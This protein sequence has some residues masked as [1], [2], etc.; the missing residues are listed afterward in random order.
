MSTPA[1]RMPWITTARRASDTKEPG[2]TT[3]LDWIRLGLRDFG[4]A[5]GLSLLYG[6]L[7]SGMCACVFALILVFPWFT[8][9]FLTAL[10][11]VAPFF[12][13]ILYATS[14]DIERDTV[15]SLSANLRLVFRRRTYLALF[16]LMLALVMAAWVRLSALLFALKFAALTPTVEAYTRVAAS[17]DGWITLAFLLAIGL[18]LATAVFLISAFA[19]PMI[20]DRGT[21][22][23]TATHKSCQSV[24]RNPGVMALWVASILVLTGIGVATAFVGLI[25]VLPVVGYA[26]WHSYRALGS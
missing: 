15:P 9:G 1:H 14:R 6:S 19:V 12:A 20:L 16:A 23:M 22:F 3:P 7:I 8:T 11:V 4:R 26:T 24:S 21:D 2:L 5:P 25:F 13:A 18:M 17:P 10:L